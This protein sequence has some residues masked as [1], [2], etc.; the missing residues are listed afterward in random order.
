MG[1]VQRNGN[2][3]GAHVKFQLIPL[4]LAAL[5]AGAHPRAGEPSSDSKLQAEVS[6]VIHDMA[7]RWAAD[8]W[9]TIPTDL[10]D[11]NE[12]N[13]TYLAEEQPGWRIGWAQVREYFDP[14][15]GFIEAAD[16]EAS[17]ITAHAIAPDL[18]V[19]TWSIYWQMKG[20]RMAPIGERLRAS[21]VLRRT[22]QG[23]KFIHYSESPKSASVYLQDLY[24]QQASPEFKA[25]AAEKAKQKASQ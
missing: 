18:A 6:A 12:P 22:P 7:S 17:D 20:R 14:K 4:A 23:W 10:W 3:H 16:Y 25:R 11:Q 1:A 24:S 2:Q 15:G 21:A 8:T 5:L 13:P 19:A 9:T